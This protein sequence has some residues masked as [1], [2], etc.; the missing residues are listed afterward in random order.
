MRGILINAKEKI[1]TEVR[2]DEANF[3]DS[4]YKHLGVSVIETAPFID[5]PMTPFSEDILYVDEEGLI[6][7][8]NFGFKAKYRDGT[9]EFRG[10]GL[11]LGL[12]DEGD[13]LSCSSTIESVKNLVIEFV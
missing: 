8:T 4:V 11:I 3:L 6:N 10:N 5:L 7:G 9:Y 1:I 12:D 2:V 13:N